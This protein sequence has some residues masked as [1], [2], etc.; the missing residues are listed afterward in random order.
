MSEIEKWGSEGKVP[1]QRARSTD[2]IERDKEIML[3]DVS[4]SPPP[5][6]CD[7]SLVIDSLNWLWREGMIR[8][9]RPVSTR[10][11][12]PICEWMLSYT[13][14][15][16][17]VYLSLRW[18]FS[19]IMLSLTQF[20]STRLGRRK[21]RKERKPKKKR[22]TR[23]QTNQT[24]TNIHTTRKRN[25]QTL[26]S[27]NNYILNTRLMSSRFHILCLDQLSDDWNCWVKM[28]RKKKRR[29]E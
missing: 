20:S 9:V 10:P 21:E 4:E 27:G 28:W 7:C 26:D 15:T 19:P 11:N 17:L 12:P 6:F 29:V 2:D 13:P 1:Y 18:L 16:S 23:F 3:S 24:S 8:P 5:S 14:L 22:Q 25:K